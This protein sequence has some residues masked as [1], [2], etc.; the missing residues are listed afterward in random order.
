L[1]LYTNNYVLELPHGH[2]EALG[3]A[4]PMSKKIHQI[5]L[6]E[7]MPWPEKDKIYYSEAVRII[8]KHPF[9][10]VS[11]SILRAGN[12]FTG[13][14]RKNI[15]YNIGYSPGK[16]FPS[17]FNNLVVYLAGIMNIIYLALALHSLVFRSNKSILRESTVIL[18]VL[19]YFTTI[20]SVSNAFI[21]YSTPI[22]PYIIIF[23][24]HTISKIVR[25]KSKIDV[26]P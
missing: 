6:D 25:K 22:F 19:I 18:T 9:K 20:H 2:H 15:L 1:N 3:P 16:L 11:H 7:S 26:Q 5:A 8:L 17:W 24:G 21:R 13:L 23:A 10:M 4:F 14:K 12:F